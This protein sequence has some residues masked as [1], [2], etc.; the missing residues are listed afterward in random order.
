[1]CLCGCVYMYVCM[2]CM[3]KT[4]SYT[5]ICMHVL[6]CTKPQLSEISP[7]TIYVHSYNY[8]AI[9]IQNAYNLFVSQNHT[10]FVG[11][12]GERE[13]VHCCTNEERFFAGEE[14]GDWEPRDERDDGRGGIVGN[15]C[16]VKRNG[17]FLSAYT[18]GA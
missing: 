16:R 1:M 18:T 5:N 10:L 9:R 17:R 7:T 14:G 2:Y 12:V 11:G 8:F 13:Y 15:R 3:Y 6:M 4:S